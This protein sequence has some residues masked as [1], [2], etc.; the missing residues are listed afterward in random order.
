LKP[1]PAAARVSLILKPP[2]AAARVSLILT[3]SRRTLSYNQGTPLASVRFPCFTNGCCFTACCKGGATHKGES[4]LFGA[5]G[6]G[7]LG[8]PGGSAGGW[9]GRG[10]RCPQHLRA[11][12]T[13]FTPRIPRYIPDWAVSAV[14]PAAVCTGGDEPCSAPPVPLRRA[15]LR[16]REHRGHRCQPCFSAGHARIM[17]T[18]RLGAVGSRP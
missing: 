2:P 12:S 18:S 11:H 5:D 10:G 7:G 4:R 3:A 1:P 14:P 6:P 15:P 17:D 16:P 13:T 8:A 9:G